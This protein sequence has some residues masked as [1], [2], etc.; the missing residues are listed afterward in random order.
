MIFPLELGN[1]MDNSAGANAQI[2]ASPTPC[3][4]RPRKKRIE[5]LAK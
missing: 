4:A 2:G 5:L 1:L 3:N